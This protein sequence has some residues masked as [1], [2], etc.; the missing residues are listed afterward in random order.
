MTKRKDIG[1]V[2]E[3]TKKG[4]LPKGLEQ[5]GKFWVDEF[6]DYHFH[7]TKTE[8]GDSPV[9]TEWS[10]KYFSIVRGTKR[11]RINISMK[12]EELLIGQLDIAIKKLK[13][14]LTELQYIEA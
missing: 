7:P 2:T 3:E 8:T 9:K 11:T 13:K 14:A 4:A 12:N 5:R 6:G 10:E 1:R